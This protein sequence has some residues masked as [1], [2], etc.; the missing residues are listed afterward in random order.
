MPVNDV[1]FGFG[2]YLVSV[3][4]VK[5]VYKLLFFYFRE[6]QSLFLSV[7]CMNGY[8]GLV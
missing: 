7:S 3:I 1:H 4:I 5:A 8:M 6:K 2:V